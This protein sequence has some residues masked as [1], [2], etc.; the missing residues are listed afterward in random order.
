MLDSDSDDLLALQLGGLHD[1]GLAVFEVLLKTDCE[2]RGFIEK[3]FDPDLGNAVH[4]I[5]RKQFVVVAAGE[6]C[7]KAHNFSEAMPLGALMVES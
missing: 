5:L 7:A 6:N 3:L 1:A 4:Q 2:A